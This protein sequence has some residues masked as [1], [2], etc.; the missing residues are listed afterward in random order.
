MYQAR[1]DN[2]V[3]EFMCFEE[4]EKS[5]LSNIITHYDHAFTL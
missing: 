2:A 4:Y 3:L 1:F 5:S